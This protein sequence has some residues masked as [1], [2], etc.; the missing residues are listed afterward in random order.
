MLGYGG[1]AVADELAAYPEAVDYG[2]EDPG[3]DAWELTGRR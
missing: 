1:D 3:E 2:D